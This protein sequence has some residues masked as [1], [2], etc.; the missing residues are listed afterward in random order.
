LLPLLRLW[1]GWVRSPVPVARVQVL[2]RLVKALRVVVLRVPW[3][4]LP[5]RNGGA[6][7]VLPTPLVRDCSA[8]PALARLLDSALRLVARAAGLVALPDLHRVFYSRLAVGSQTT[9]LEL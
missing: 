6:V 1:A 4:R 5:L 3:M 9:P 7:R 8:R 2:R